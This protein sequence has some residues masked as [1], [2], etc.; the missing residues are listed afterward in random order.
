MWLLN[1]KTLKLKH[2]ARERD[3]TAKYAILSHTWA[4][5]EVSF[6]DIRSANVKVEKKKGYLKVKYAARQAV[7]DGLD[8]VWI[9]SE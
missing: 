3:V 5:E 6:Q 4:E 2:I 1:A 8:Y 7:S 9:V